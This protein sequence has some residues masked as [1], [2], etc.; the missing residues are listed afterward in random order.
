MPIRDTSLDAEQVQL[1]VFRRMTGEQ[2]LKLALEMS[3]FARGL[4]LSRIRAEHPEWSDWEVKRELL[5]LDFL[6]DPLPAGLP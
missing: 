1:D 6:P 3:D 2:R 4:S 5:R